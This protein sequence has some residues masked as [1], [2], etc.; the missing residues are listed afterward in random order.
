MNAVSALFRDWFGPLVLGSTF[1]VTSACSSRNAS[2]DAKPSDA[3]SAVPI[4]RVVCIRHPSG[5]HTTAATTPL[6]SRQ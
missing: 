4:S 6:G 5:R 1:L 3:L 2:T